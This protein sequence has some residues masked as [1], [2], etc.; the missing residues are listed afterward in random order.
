MVLIIDI[1]LPKIGA[2]RAD[3]LALLA[4]K[5][6]DY[7]AGPEACNLPH[8]NHPPAS[9]PAKQ[10]RSLRPSVRRELIAAAGVREH[11]PSQ[12]LSVRAK[13]FDVWAAGRRD[14]IWVR[15]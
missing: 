9:L 13:V 11:V 5:A 2:Q 15:V 7:H 3:R 14:P 6:S 10:S 12:H 4:N 8:T 1:D